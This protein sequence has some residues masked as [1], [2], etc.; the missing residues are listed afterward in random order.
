MNIHDK[1]NRRG[2]I[3][4]VDLAENST[5]FAHKLA[6]W[7]MKAYLKLRRLRKIKKDTVHF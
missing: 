7:Q 3:I 6:R 5:W 4:P 2:G 1:I